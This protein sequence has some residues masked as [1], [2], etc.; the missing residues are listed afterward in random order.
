MSAQDSKPHSIQQLIQALQAARDTAR[1][2]L[3]LLSLDAKERFSE[4]EGKVQ[5][6]EQRLQTGGEKAAAGASAAVDELTHAVVEFVRTVEGSPGTRIQDLMTRDPSSCLAS[7]SLSRAAQIMWDHDCGAVPVVDAEGTLVGI[8]TD[9]DICIATHTR[10]QPPAA[11][12]VDAIMAKDVRV[13]SPADLLEDVARLMAERQLRRLPVVEGGRLVGMFTLADLAR[14][15]RT[16]QGSNVPEWLMLARTLA[17]IS[18]KKGRA[19]A[20]A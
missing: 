1:M 17:A 4:I 14:H 10:G 20:A 13:A 2:R 12:T 6:L 11:I 5:D 19:S 15:V 7:D 3:H 9:R 16:S 8:V 18:E